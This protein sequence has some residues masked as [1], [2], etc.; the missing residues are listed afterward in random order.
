[1][2][3]KGETLLEVLIALTLITVSVAAAA[4]AMMSAT[5]GLSL[6]KNYLIA[7]NLASE[8]LEIVKNIRDTN[9]MKFPVDKEDCW[10]NLKT[11]IT[12]SDL[13]DPLKY[14]DGQNND[15]Y[16]AVENNMF[17]LKPGH[18]KTMG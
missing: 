9:W 15:Y 16:I 7:Q 3:K 14:I 12:T 10:L 2:N 8:G 17:T 11:D 5:K 18:Q 4:S 6:S 1:M 13:C